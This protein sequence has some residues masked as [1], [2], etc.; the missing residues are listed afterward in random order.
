[1]LIR[2]DKNEELEKVLAQK[3]VDEQAKNLLQGIL[4]KIEVSYKDYQKVKVKK[5]TEEEYIEELIKN[6]EK[7]CN[8]IS[9]VKLNQDLADKEIKE[10][11]EKNKFYTGEELV[12]YPIEEKFLYAIEKQSRYRKILNNKYGEIT[13]AISEL[14]NE[15]KN[16]DR[17]EVLRDFNG[18]SWTTINNEIE[19]I[20]ANLI[21]QMLQIML[22]E[23]FLTNWCQDKD[24]IIDYLEQFMEEMTPKY[25]R[26]MANEQKDLIIKIAMANNAKEN[27]KFSQEIE[28][29]IEKTE[30]ELENFENT[31]Q[32]I[33]EIGER[34]KQ[35]LQELN[36]LER[37]LGQDANL[38]EEFEKRNEETPIFNIN[39]FKKQLKNKKEQILEQIE[40]YNYLQNPLN[41]LEEKN[42]IMERQQRL[43]IAK[44]SQEELE[45]F[46]IQ[47]TEN[48][49]KCFNI[50]IEKTKDERIVELIYKFR[51]FM[52]L[53]FDLEKSI[54]DVDQLKTSI[55]DTEEKLIQKA[56]NRKVI[57]D[58]PYE[59]IKHVLETR[60]IILEDLYYKITTKSEK[61]YVQLF[62]ENVSEEKFEI[63]PV[64]KTKI[65]KKIKIF[66]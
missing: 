23:E 31:Q 36:E 65:N 13:I 54:K 25:G 35:L 30:R 49:F 33:S 12:S 37:I 57:V 16:L 51:Y 50:L 19:N 63:T 1:M 24:G 41:Y 8:K 60:I 52:M 40:Q 39:L 5:Q 56:I 44:I 28:E 46:I 66:I 45:R 29:K 34:K 64:E 47:F 4:Y 14:I 42:K 11:L 26:K 6:L 10:E 43:K 32:K 3:K 17:I 15:G 22:G 20:N 18:W 27:S 2:K 59:I 21:Y 7:N 48:F 38:K 62:D 55:T 61:Y 9:I 53:P 58:M